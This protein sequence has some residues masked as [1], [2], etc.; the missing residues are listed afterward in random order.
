[1]NMNPFNQ[2]KTQNRD[3]FVRTVGLS[4]EKFQYLVEQ[5]RAN[6]QV[7]QAHNPLKKRGLQAELSLENQV[8]LAL[9]YLRNYSTFIQ[10][11][12]QFGI[13]ESYAHKI[14]HKMSAMWVKIL[15]VK[16]RQALFDNPIGT[17]VVDVTEQPIE[18]P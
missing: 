16:S 12:L 17:L 18:R 3:N 15:H 9:L 2:Y 1:M 6:L 7:Q 14:Y 10:L 8:L 4:L 5:T 13:S 11:G